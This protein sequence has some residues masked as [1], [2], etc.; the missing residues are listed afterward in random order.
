MDSTM[1]GRGYLLCASPR[2][3]STLL[4]DLLTRSQLAGDPRSY[5]RPASIPEFAAEW[6]VEIGA[7]DGDAAYGRA[8]RQ[9]G[10]AG[11]GCFGMRI[12]WSDMGSFLSRLRTDADQDQTDTQLLSSTFGIDR[13][14]HLIRSDKVAQAV[15][16]AIARQTG[17]WHRNADG[18]ERERDRSHR[19]LR[20]DH[21]QIG[22]E[23]RMLEAEEAG[24]QNWFSS[25]GITPLALRYEQL[26]EDPGASLSLV[27]EHLDRVPEHRLEP[28]TAKLATEVNEAWALRFRASR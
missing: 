20:Y 28:G 16:L 3:G 10:D 6:A 14:V 22:T 23:L 7:A 11:T 4:C 18:T 19:P 17:L 24:W 12:M 25:A 21:D 8:V 2:S 9:H 5:F 1:S 26:A 27:L 13:Y 15:S